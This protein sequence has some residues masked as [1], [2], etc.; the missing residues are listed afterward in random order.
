MGNLDRATNERLH[1]LD[2]KKLTKTA[3]SLRKRW[4]QLRGDSRE[5]YD[6][7]CSNFV[8]LKSSGVVLDEYT[9]ATHLWDAQEMQ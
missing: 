4:S 6:A 2:D 3:E 1:A 7:L 5:A 9:P 8:A